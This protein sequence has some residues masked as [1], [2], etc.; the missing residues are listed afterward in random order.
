MKRPFFI[1]MMTALL[2]V[3]GCTLSTLSTDTT[4]TSST[5][6]Q[7][8]TTTTTTDT[9]S[10]PVTAE[11]DRIALL[12]PEWIRDD[13]SLP[14]ASD[15]TVSIS[16][17]AQ[18]GTIE[19]GV[20]RYL[21]TH[22]DEI[23]TLSVTAE[24]S[25]FQATRTFY[26]VSL[27]DNDQYEQHLID[28][29]FEEIEALLVEAF[30]TQIESDFTMPEVEY[31]NTTFR[32]T[33][34]TSHVYNGRF[35]FPFPTT[36]SFLTVNV[37][38]N[39]KNNIREIPVSIFMKGWN[40]LRQIPIVNINTQNSQTVTSKEDYIDA[41]L[42][43]VVFDDANQSTEVY[44]NVPIQIR[45]RGNSTLW[46]P[47]KSYRIKFAEKMPF[48]SEYSE[49]DWV[50]LANF[51][52]QTL[53]RNKLAYDLARSMNMAF[54]PMAEFVDIY[55]NGSYDGN[56]M[57]TDQIEV[58]NNRVNIE[59]KSP[60]VDTGYLI[61][62]D[63]RQGMEGEVEGWDY[64]NLYGNKY[65]IKS[66]KTDSAY[67]SVNQLYYIESYMLDVYSTLSNIQPY[68]QLID[69]ASWVDW[70]IINELFKNVD[71]G[72]S[73]VYYYKDRGGKL[74]MGPIWDF[75]LS[76]SNPGH[77]SDGER[78]PLGWY[79]SLPYKNRLFYYLMQSTQFQQA[80]KARWN[81][82]YDSQ[83]Q[84]MVDSI[85]PLSDSI[86]KSRYENFSRW[87]V[88]GK[89]YEWYTSTEVYAA[90]TYEEQVEILYNYLV[91]RK[92]WMN[93]EINKF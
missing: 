43:L 75:D 40:D 81:E 9:R 29:A 28:V 5:S 17:E 18:N 30:P 49:R 69:E 90:K 10:I 59:E 86:A 70:F 64:F 25:G 3:T 16:Y 34:S 83:I 54:A 84:D 22:Q 52:D 39:Y 8:S 32:Y 65:A 45:A 92:A 1:L 7:T 58:T 37:R 15:Q 79:T 82:I 2:F 48:L 72:Y 61:E 50:L 35:I 27:R 88:I 12:I 26:I 31:E 66:P 85:Y 56:Y 36:G 42:S 47:K 6:T 78:Q 77:L 51:A 89:N 80:L 87:D 38:V 21:P 62:L 63:A 23:V 20:L 41:T 55:M 67:Y 4:T 71:S 76:T 14:V 93:E 19:Q 74:K 44:T 24:Y 13:F 60:A 46:M 73:S 53:I 91:V 68:D 33:V 11:L 57:L